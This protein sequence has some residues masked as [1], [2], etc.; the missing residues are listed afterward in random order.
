MLN[1]EHTVTSY[2]LLDNKSVILRP[3]VGPVAFFSPNVPRI[4]LTD[5]R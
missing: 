4:G 1:G 5:L 2:L 3:G